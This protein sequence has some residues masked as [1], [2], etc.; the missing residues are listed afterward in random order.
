[1]PEIAPR[2]VYDELAAVAPLVLPYMDCVW[3]LLDDKRREAV[4]PILKCQQDE[5]RRGRILTQKGYEIKAVE[6]FAAP[7]PALHE[8][9]A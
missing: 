7:R 2:T 3:R 9:G 4:K 8:A 1:M 6:V 5:Y